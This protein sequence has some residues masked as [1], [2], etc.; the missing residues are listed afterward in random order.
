MPILH[1]QFTLDV[2]V[3]QFLRACSDTELQELDLLL[4]SYLQFVK[5]ES[6]NEPLKIDP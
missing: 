3:E 1:K 5:K 6:N 4:P 2:T